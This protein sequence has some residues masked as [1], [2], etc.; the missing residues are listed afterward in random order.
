[1]RTRKVMKKK[2]QTTMP[3]Y[4]PP[5]TIS[6][7]DYLRGGSD[8]EF[9]ETI[10][11]LVQC[12]GR[13]LTC[14]EAFGQSLGLTASQYAVLIGV[15]YRQ[16]AEGVNIR[17][18]SQHIALAPTHVTTEVGRLVRKGLLAK[19]PSATDGR[20]V[21]I[22][23]S[24]RGRTAISDVAPFVRSINDSLFEDVLLSDLDSCR[25]VVRLIFRNSDNVLSELR[26]HSHAVDETRTIRRKTIA[27][28]GRDR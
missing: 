7:S 20:S 16:G 17:D 8:A 3:A 28:T 15:A 26:R 2:Q 4:K 14:R 23:L 24:A 18:L 9:R 19:R 6:R 1:M 5:H 13:L 25:K 12:V 27:T 11:A 10:Y 21:L 22:S